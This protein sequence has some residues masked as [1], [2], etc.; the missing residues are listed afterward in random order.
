MIGLASSGHRRLLA[1][2]IAALGFA[3]PATAEPVR[4]LSEIRGEGVV[5]QQWDK[6]CAAAALATVLTY[7]FGDPVPEREVAAGLM[8]QTEP[9]KVRHRGGFSLLDM[10]RYAQERGYR[11]YGFTGMT[12]DDIRHMDAPIVPVQFVNGYDHYVVFK[13][14]RPDGKVWIADPAFGNYDLA[15]ERFERMWKGGM[16][17]VLLKGG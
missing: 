15:R 5:L 10:K 9:L 13:G 6:S 11:A 14:L 7:H 2:L 4:S 16:A 1:I 8:R 3:L 17:F 12:F